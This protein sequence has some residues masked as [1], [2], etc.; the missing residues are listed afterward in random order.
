MQGVQNTAGIPRREQKLSPVE[1]EGP[2][3]AKKGFLEA[4]PIVILEIGG[5]C[6]G[7]RTQLAFGRP[8]LISGAQAALNGCFLCIYT[9]TQYTKVRGDAL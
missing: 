8:L 2:Q 3:G 5:G 6:G 4:F 7:I 1:Q 9:S